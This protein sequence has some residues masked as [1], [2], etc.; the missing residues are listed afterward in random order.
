M[1]AL[2]TSLLVCKAFGG[3]VAYVRVQYFHVPSPIKHAMNAEIA[4]LTT[5]REPIFLFALGSS[6]ILD[7]FTIDYRI[8][9]PCD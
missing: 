1:A 7:G 5:N 9:T 4:I 2:G 8:H 3:G 6:F